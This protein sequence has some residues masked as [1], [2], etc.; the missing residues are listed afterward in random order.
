MKLNTIISIVMIF[1]F[2]SSIYAQLIPVEIDLS[3]K[4]PTYP[5]KPSDM[6]HFTNNTDDIELS[7]PVSVLTEEGEY[8][9]G[10]IKFVSGSIDNIITQIHV[11]DQATGQK[12]KLKLENIK[13]VFIGT[14]KDVKVSDLVNQHQSISYVGDKDLSKVMISKSQVSYFEKINITKGKKVKPVLLQAI[15][16]DSSNEVTVFYDPKGKNTQVKVHLQIEEKGYKFKGAVMEFVP[17]SYYVKN[18]ANNE[19]AQISEKEFKKSGGNYPENIFMNQAVVTRL[20][21]G[22]EASVIKYSKDNW[23]F[24]LMNAINYNQHVQVEL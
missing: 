23:A 18:N 4:N 15:N 9:S 10:Q 17:N 2:S 11:K 20:N 22:N 12:V 7:S 24:F 3:K 16:Y 13:S 6:P 21:E 1:F 14:S 19:V 8:V 5:F